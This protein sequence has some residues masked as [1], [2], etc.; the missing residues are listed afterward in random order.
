MSLKVEP[1][2]TDNYRYER[3]FIVSSLTKDEVEFVIKLHPAMFMETYSPRFVNNLYFD[4]YG[5]NSYFDNTNGLKK[6][7]KARIRWYGDLFGSVD[8]PVLEIKAKDGS[9]GSKKSFP[10]TPFSVDESLQLD[11]ILEV[12]ER[13]ELPNTLQ[14]DLLSLGFSLLNRYLRKYFQSADRKYRLTI[15]SGLTFYQIRDYSNTFL[16]KSVDYD[17][18]VVELKYAPEEDQY[19]NQISNQFPFRMTKNSK[20]VSGIERL[21]L[22]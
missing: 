19:V 4:S 3:K 9:L 5:L 11:T 14:L 20:Y 16:Y 7:M 13:S 15:D 1:P 18:T 8:H 21:N 10:L 22:W 2:N 12:F 6:R 17:N